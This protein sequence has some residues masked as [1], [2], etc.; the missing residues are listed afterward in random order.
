MIAVQKALAPTGLSVYAAI[1]KPTV[2]YQEPPEQYL[3]YSS[4]TTEDEHYDDQP[5]STQTF[6]YLNLWS[7]TDPTDAAKAVRRAMRAAGFAMM[8]ESDKGYNHPAYNVDANLFTVGWTWV[9]RE[10]IV[11][12]I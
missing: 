3:V 4:T 1:W 6:V 5:I 7:L 12:G 8:E 10:M 11:D 2:E 9:Y